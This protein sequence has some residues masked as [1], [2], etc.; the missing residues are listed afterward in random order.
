[1][2]KLETPT[3]PSIHIYV[4]MINNR[5]KFKIKDGYKLGLQAPETMKLNGSTK[6][7][8]RQNKDC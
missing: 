7:V 2:K 4:S 1:M 8:N 5:L 3:N 6:K